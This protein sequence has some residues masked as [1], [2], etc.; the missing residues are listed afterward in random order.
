MS[1]LPTAYL[2]VRAPADIMID[3]Q[4]SLSNF[5][6]FARRPLYTDTQTYHHPTNWPCTSYIHGSIG[7]L[8]FFETGVIYIDRYVQKPDSYDDV[9]V[10]YFAFLDR[11]ICK[12]TNKTPLYIQSD[13]YTNM[14]ISDIEK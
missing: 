13:I 1:T 14:T 9:T 12:M 4:L 5:L 10:I 2:C 6:M 11:Q 7:F 8:L 3:C